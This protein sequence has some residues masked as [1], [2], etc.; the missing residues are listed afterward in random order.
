MCYNDRKYSFLFLF[1]PWK[2]LQLTWTR[3]R[4]E[5]ERESFTYWIRLC[6]SLWVC[7]WNDMFL[8]R[9]V[10]SRICARLSSNEWLLRSCR[11]SPV[12]SLR[13]HFDQS[14]LLLFVIT[15]LFTVRSVRM[16]PLWLVQPTPDAGKC[17]AWCRVHVLYPVDCG[18]SQ[19]LSDMWSLSTLLTPLRFISRVLKAILQRLSSQEH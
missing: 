13:P 11:L 5:T 14:S 10:S 16:R 15:V 19:P 8:S 7:I 12:V 2:T 17:L 9:R 3:G 4:S 1:T 6:F 18:E